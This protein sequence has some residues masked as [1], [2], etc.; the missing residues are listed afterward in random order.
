MAVPIMTTVKF[1]PLLA[2]PPTVTITG[3]VVA[4]TG[5]GVTMFVVLQLVGAAAPP[6]NVTILVPCVDPKPVPLMVTE[7]PTEPEL[8][9]R[10]VI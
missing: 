9:D 7:F 10:P 8:G 4:D 5:T 6:L 1:I 3:P 2:L